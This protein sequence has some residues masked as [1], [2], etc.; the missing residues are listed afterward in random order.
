RDLPS[1]PRSTLGRSPDRTCIARNSELRRAPARYDSHIRSTSA[2]HTSH[3]SPDDT[4]SLPLS[5]AHSSRT[6]RA[7]VTSPT[8]FDVVTFHADA[9]VPSERPATTGGVSILLRVVY[10]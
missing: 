8:A 10:T 7:S 2:C 9:A 6:E 1:N 5:F 3:T 4:L